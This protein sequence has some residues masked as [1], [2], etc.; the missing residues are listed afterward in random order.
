MWPRVSAISVLRRLKTLRL[1]RWSMGWQ[2]CWVMLSVSGRDESHRVLMNQPDE[3]QRVLRVEPAGVLHFWSYA[4]LAYGLFKTSPKCETRTPEQ[5]D[6]RRLTC[7]NN[8]FLLYRKPPPKLSN[9]RQKS[10]V[11]VHES[12]GHLQ[13]SAQLAQA[14]LITTGLASVSGVG[15]VLDR[16]THRLTIGWL[17]VRCVGNVSLITW[18]G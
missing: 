4:R 17:V 7:Y 13:D 14:C 5:Q 9:L 10:F 12:M 11:N 16:L 15:L 2:A 1:L 8:G 18:W 6:K 3:E